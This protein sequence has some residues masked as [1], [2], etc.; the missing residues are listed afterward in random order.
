MIRP[1]RLLCQQRRQLLKFFDVS[2]T[3]NRVLAGTLDIEHNL[4]L[5]L[6]DQGRFEQS[7]EVFL[8]GIELVAAVY[9][10]DAASR[11]HNG[12]AKLYADWGRWELAERYARD[13]VDYWLRLAGVEHRSTS[14]R[15]TLLGRILVRLGRPQEALEL[16]EASLRVQR[17]TMPVGR[18]ERHKT[19]SVLGAAYSML[20]RFEEAEALL[21]DSYPRI[22]G[23]RGADHHRTAQALLRLVEHYERRGRPE[24]A[25]RYRDLI[26]PR[27]R[28]SRIVRCTVPPPEGE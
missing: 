8:E 28:E 1:P 4:A 7:E 9:G 13:A 25:Q 19:A 6:K 12:L 5:L 18:W 23:D 15:F 21:L 2:Q 11:A 22:A 20:G 16:L 17:E 27:A 3:F 26:T 24:E 10:A 14:I